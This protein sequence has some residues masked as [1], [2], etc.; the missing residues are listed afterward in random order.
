MKK[1]I[2]ASIMA[3][4]IFILSCNKSNDPAPPTTQELIIGNWN[5]QKD[6]VWHKSAGMPITKDT[7]NQYPGEYDDYRADGKIYKTYLVSLAPPVY[8]HDTAAYLIN[9]TVQKISYHGAPYFTSDVQ[10]LTST[11]F[12]YH[13]VQI[14]GTDTTEYWTYF[15]K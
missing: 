1:F 12:M 13:F 10:T 8:T 11:D 15:K 2:P 4:A 9:G 6:I 7:V 5:H 3:L 14:S